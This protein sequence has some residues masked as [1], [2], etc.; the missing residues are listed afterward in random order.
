MAKKSNIRQRGNSWVIR[1]RRDGQPVWRSFKTKDE[2][3]LEL[4]RA[5]VRKAQGQ[6]EPNA[7]RMTVAE[8]A[9][10]WL[11]K[12][13]GRVGE[14]TLVNYANVLNVHV[15]PSLGDLELRRVSRKMLD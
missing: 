10:E 8:H 14:Q 7:R 3:E 1:Y 15:L 12:K 13:R 5:M 9:G 2:A 4:A 6:P 11:D